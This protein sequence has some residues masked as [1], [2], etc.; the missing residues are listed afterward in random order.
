MLP[1]QAYAGATSYSIP[2]GEN[3]FTGRTRRTMF[4]FTA[5]DIVAFDDDTQVFINSP[6]VPGAP[7]RSP[8]TAAS[9]TRTATGTTPPRSTAPAGRSTTVA[10]GPHHQRRHQDLVDGARRDPALHRHHRELRHRLHAGRARPPPRQRL[11]PSDAGR[12]PDPAGL[13]PPQR[14]PVQPGLGERDQRH[15]LR[16]HPAHEHD[17]ARGERHRGLRG[18]GRPDP[19]ELHGPPHLEPLLLGLLAPRPPHCLERL[20]LLVAG[21][22]LP[23]ERLHGILRPGR[24][25]PGH[26][27]D[28]P[29]ADRPR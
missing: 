28:R 4:R 14:L 26:E 6:G 17:P 5:I 29:S 23:D 24:Q 2:V 3:R 8:S 11:H 9:T 27:L 7:S 13:A 18:G 12:R 10:G 19:G 16:P 21:L 22:E 25:R 15:R 1:R 20:G